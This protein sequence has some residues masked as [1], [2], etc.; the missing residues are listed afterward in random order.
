VLGHKAMQA[1][2]LGLRSPTEFPRVIQ[3]V[4]GF[5]G[6]RAVVGTEARQ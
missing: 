1:F 6:E 5:L 3:S 4:G 2:D